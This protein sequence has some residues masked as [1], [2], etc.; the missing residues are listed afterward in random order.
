MAFDIETYKR[1]VRPVDL[2]G[3]DFAA[4]ETQPL[5][6][7]VLRCLRYMHDVEQH[8]VCYLRDLLVTRAHLDPEITTFLTLWNFEELWHGEAIARVLEAHGEPGGAARLGPL[9]RGLGW[10]NVFAPLVSMAVS[11][12][13]RNLSAVHM[14]WGAVNEWTT[15]AGYARLAARADHPV[16]S[17]LLRRIMRQEGRHIDF[18]VAQAR[19]RLS[20]SRAAR[21]ATRLAL[22]RFWRPVGS[23][24]MPRREVDF[25]IGYLFA[26]DEG[27]AMAE[28]IDRRVSALPGLGGLELISS[29]RQAA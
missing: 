10:K 11:A 16:L 12:L 17:E 7:A 2:E 25:L 22:T 20:S 14:T 23:G 29:A 18:Y 19:Q 13:S 4:F 9:R 1:I 26:G 8:T 21:I 15:Q 24:V 27:A 3:I 6:P 28:R 5:D